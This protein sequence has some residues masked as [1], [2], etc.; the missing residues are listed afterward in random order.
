M[1]ADRTAVTILAIGPAPRGI[2][3]TGRRIRVAV[4]NLELLVGE[5]D[6]LAAAVADVYPKVFR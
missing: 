3:L 4:G 5:G 2:G 1:L 6:D